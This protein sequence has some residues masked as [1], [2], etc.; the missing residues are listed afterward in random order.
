MA[1]TFE[2]KAIKT[3]VKSSLKVLYKD[4]LIFVY[5]SICVVTPYTGICKGQ[6]RVLDTLKL[7]L[8]AVVS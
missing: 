2:Y 6:K 3:T 4:I 1:S 8:Q 5:E 7:E